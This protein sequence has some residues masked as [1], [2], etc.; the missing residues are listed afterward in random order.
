MKTSIRRIPAAILLLVLWLTV[1]PISA[2]AEVNVEVE[3]PVSIELSGETPSP[4]ETYTVVLQ[5]V[6]DA[7]MPAES[8]LEITGESSAVFPV[9]YSTP[10]IYCY[11]IFQQ[12]GNHERG[13]YDAVVYYV[14]VTVTNGESG[15]LQAVIA[16]HTDE[17][18]VSEKQDIT[19]YND[20]DPAP[21]PTIQTQDT[22]KKPTIVKAAEK[23]QT[24]SSKIKNAN[25][26]KTGD[27]TNVIL[28][29]SLLAGSVC[30]LGAVGFHKKRE[31]T[32][33][34]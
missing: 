33:N 19:F 13:N 31:N 21:V 14:K 1:S 4:E 5:A 15:G 8:T 24:S 25:P 26:V 29:A 2:F 23:S 22:A 28:W 20:Y 34:S 11:K 30:T 12:V 32:K 6:D 3:I 27:S 17:Q 7:P 18:M 9:S 10:G 16:A